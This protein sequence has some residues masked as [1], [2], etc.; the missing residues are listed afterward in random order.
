MTNLQ[1]PIL[2]KTEKL[3]QLH[4]RMIAEIMDYAIIL[5]DLDGTIL[6]W[7]KG[8]QTIKGYSESDIL[9]QNFRI[10]YLPRDREEKLPEKLIDLAIKEGRAR[11]IGRRVRKDGTTFWGSILITA[12]HD[13]DGDVIGFTKL[14]KEL[15]ENEID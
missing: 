12:L 4:D 2:N 15:G 14:T 9:G 3:Q 6:T 8:A 1:N 11:H 10:F 7:N 5:L 13:D